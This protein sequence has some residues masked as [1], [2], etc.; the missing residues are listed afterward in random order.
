M[1][2][3]KV[4]NASVK[5]EEKTSKRVTKGP[6]GAKISVKKEEK[7]SKPVTKGRKNAVSWE[8]R[9]AECKDFLEKNNHCRIPTDFKEN[10]SLGIWVQETRR[11]FKAMMMGK[12][13]RKFLTP[14]QIDQL[15]EIEFH[16]GFKRDPNK[17]PE[18]DESWETNFAKLNQYKKTHGNFDVPVDVEDNKVLRKLGIW[19]RVQRTQKYYRD[20]KRKCF[21]TKKRIKQLSDAGFDWK[22]NRETNV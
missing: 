12:K 1:V 18:T 15:D 2:A 22:G 5:K 16:W 19:V 9:C 8:K 21:I 7:T 14:E 13:P 17:I 20:T 6:I 4:E 10:K 3:V 11:N